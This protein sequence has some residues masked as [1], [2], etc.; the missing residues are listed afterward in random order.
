MVVVG[1]PAAV[2]APLATMNFGATTLYDSLGQ[3]TA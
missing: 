1:D 3:P 2:C